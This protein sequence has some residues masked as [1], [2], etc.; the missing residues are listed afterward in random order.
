MSKINNVLYF[1]LF[2]G[3]A[4]IYILL[5]PYE[6]AFYTKN[7]MTMC[8]SSVIP[9]LFVFMVFT[10]ILAKLCA[11]GFMSG[12]I[13]GFFSRL[14][15]LPVCLVPICLAGLV[16]GAPS[17]TV[18]ICSLYSEGHCSKDES[19]RACILTGNCSGAFIMGVVSATLGCKFASAYILISNL[20][21]TLTIYLLLYRGTSK[22]TAAKPEKSVFG[23]YDALSESIVSSASS[24]ITLSA[25]VVFFYTVGATVSTKAAGVLQSAGLSSYFVNTAKSLICSLFEIGLGLN[26]LSLISGTKAIIIA[27]AAVSFTGISIIFQV[28]GIMRHHGIPIKNYIFSKLLCALLCPVYVTVILLTSPFPVSVFS[29]FTANQKQGVS[30]GDVAVLIF[31]TVI[32]FIAARFL[33]Y[34]DKKYKK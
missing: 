14:F 18:S 3:T 1:G 9:A 28:T 31:V 32:A 33:S 2:T 21:S 30:V 10:K 11:A 19:E 15:G 22:Q 34:L 26:S 25:Y 7:A 12:K 20:A 17:G 29:H 4:L 23:F 13:S 8:I 16:C 5:F 24:V 27:A 6:T